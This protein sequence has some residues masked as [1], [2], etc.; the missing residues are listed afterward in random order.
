MNLTNLQLFSRKYCSI[1][2]SKRNNRTIQSDVSNLEDNKRFVSEYN[3]AW[4]Y[5]KE[6]IERLKKIE[7]NFNFNE[8]CQCENTCEISTQSC[9]ELDQGLEWIRPCPLGTDCV[10][11]GPSTRKNPRMNTYAGVDCS[12]VSLTLTEKQWMNESLYHPHTD[13]FP[14]DLILQSENILASMKSITVLYEDTTWKRERCETDCPMSYPNRCPNGTC[15][16][17]L[18]DCELTEQTYDCKGNGCMQ[19]EA[20]KNEY[21]CVCEEFWSGPRCDFGLCR[22]GDPFV[23]NV[24]VDEICS[25][26][27]APPLR[28]KPPQA[29]FRREIKDAYFEE[30]TDGDTTNWEK[31]MPNFAPFGLALL[32]TTTL[33]T[34]ENIFTTCPYARKGINGEYFL[35]TDDAE[36]GRPWKTFTQHDDFPYR[37]RNGQCVQSPILCRVSQ[38]VR[39]ICNNGGKCIEDG[40]FKCDATN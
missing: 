25:C 21:G 11:C 28:E 4:M 16:R 14:M 40:S 23:G 38:Y 10:D 31:I 2:E 15:V 13:S 36:N 12:D 3:I 32:R 29:P 7:M 30:F 39:P 33:A 5:A 22:P 37:C 9:D 34:G 35:M 20:G 17:L 6:T 26:G 1:Q 18:E 19:F 24:P 8:T 27:G